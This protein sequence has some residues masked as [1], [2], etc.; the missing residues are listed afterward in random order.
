MGRYSIIYN[1]LFFLLILGAFASM[2]QNDYGIKIL[3]LVAASFS[4]LFSI[5]FMR[6]FQKNSEHG[7]HDGLELI[8]LAI[9]AAILT[10]R[11]FYIRIQF[12]EIAFG[13]AG[14]LLIVIYVI[15]LTQ[16]WKSISHRNKVLALL[17]AMFYGS[18]VLYLISMITVPFLP[19]L[20][21][22]SG[23]LAFAML[24]AFA[25]VSIIRKDILL[26]GEKVSGLSY[27]VEFKDR[28][29]VLVMLFILFTAYMGLTKVGAIPEM[30]SDQYPQA[31]F[32]LVKQ[33]ETGKEKP[34]NGK[35]KHE[36][37]KEMYDQFV[38]RN[39]LSD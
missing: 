6:L 11:V 27:V 3:G 4:L 8:S 33:A 18:I 24:I 26:D 20:A 19:Q 35:Y 38:S 31:Y 13:A 2:A 17:I 5:Q 14:L 1:L 34:V 15:K 16:S 9:L 21:E 36:E 28:S 29:I 32:E 39:K 22:P 23:G 10:M 37:F 7:L 30:Y 25:V 12:V